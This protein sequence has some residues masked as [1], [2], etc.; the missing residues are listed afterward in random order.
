MWKLAVPWEEDTEEAY[1]QKFKYDEL[2]KT[3]KNNGWK[4]RLAQG[5]LLQV[6]YVRPCQAL[7]WQEQEK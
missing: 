3:C 7:V 1:E 5:S 4:A 2:L 6:H